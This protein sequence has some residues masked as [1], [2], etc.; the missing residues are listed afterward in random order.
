MP[1]RE[2]VHLGRELVRV[3]RNLAAETPYSPAWAAT[4]EWHDE[5]ETRIRSLGGDPDTLA[6]S[7]GRLREPFRAQLAPT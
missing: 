2:N 5:L 1:D 3:R 7:E 4:V 6:R